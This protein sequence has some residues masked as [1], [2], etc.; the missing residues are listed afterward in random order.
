MTIQE[1]KN[2]LKE[3]MK[4]HIHLEKG[5][6]ELYKHNEKTIETVVENYIER[7]S[8]IVNFD[9]VKQIYVIGKDDSLDRNYSTV[10]FYS[11]KFEIL[12]TYSEESFNF[13][14]TYAYIV[15]VLDIEKA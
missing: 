6:H 9:V 13:L 4:S 8:P 7:Y 11:T 12:L 3:K 2:T 1:L 15:S 5:S 10:E 14:E